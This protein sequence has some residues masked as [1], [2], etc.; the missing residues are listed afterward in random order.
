MLSD[1][2]ILNRLSASFQQKLGSHNEDY[3]SHNEDYSY[4]DWDTERPSPSTKG[5]VADCS[6]EDEAPSFPLLPRI[7]SVKK[8][9]IA[10]DKR[11]R[12][13][14]FTRD[15]SSSTPRRTKRKVV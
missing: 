15:L 8:Q 1:D 13:D 4:S 12:T 2:D 5:S 7:S 10:C 11:E 6:S 3:T 14:T 9:K